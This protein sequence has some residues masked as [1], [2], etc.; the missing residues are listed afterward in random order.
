MWMYEGPDAFSS[1]HLTRAELDRDRK[2]KEN[3]PAWKGV[4]FDS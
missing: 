1:S 4:G 3:S 2:R